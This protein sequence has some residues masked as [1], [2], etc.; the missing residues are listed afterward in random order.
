V[1]VWIPFPWSV[2]IATASSART[3]AI[4]SVGG[5]S[6][7]EFVVA[8]AEVLHERVPGADHPCAAELFE[9]THRPQPGLQPSMIGFGRII[10]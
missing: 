7:A 3:A 8:A 10:R 6:K 9:A 1:A 5:S 4:R 2:Q